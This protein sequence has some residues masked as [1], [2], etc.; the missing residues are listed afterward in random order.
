M[1]TLVQPDVDRHEAVADHVQPAGQ[2]GDEPQRR[3]EQ[4]AAQARRLGALRVDEQLV[5]DAARDRAAGDQAVA[6]EHRHELGQPVL[7]D[8]GGRRGRQPRELRMR[9]GE[10]GAGVVPLVDER[11]TDAAG[12]VGAALPGL[13]DQV[14]RRA[15]ELRDR[16]HV[17]GP[18][19]HDLLPL[20][21]RVE[22]RHHA[23][24]PAGRPVA[25]Q[26]RLRRRRG[27]R[28]PRRTGSPRARRTRSPWR[29]AGACVPERPRPSGRSTRQSGGRPRSSERR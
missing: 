22:V 15:R 7:G 27:P 25:E 16:V 28:G 20:E 12:V 10:R 5:G 3:A 21:G 6:L 14:E 26:Q 13:R 24:V 1:G 2:L 29:P 17:L 23:H 19:H 8:G 9:V 18:V 11:E 4:I